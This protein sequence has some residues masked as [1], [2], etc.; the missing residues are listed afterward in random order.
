MKS[1]AINRK[2]KITQKE[3]TEFEK[4]LVEAGINK[5]ELDAIIGR[6]KAGT[7]C[8]DNSPCIHE[9]KCI[10]R[11]RSE[12]DPIGKLKDILVQKNID[13]RTLDPVVRKILE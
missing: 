6:L 3:W 4:S 1:S 8:S 2:E 12:N 10:S 9:H 7:G 13:I 11:Y 5:K